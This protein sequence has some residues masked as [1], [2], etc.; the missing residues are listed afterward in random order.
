MKLQKFESIVEAEN[1]LAEKLGREG[2]HVYRKHD[3]NNLKNWFME[4]NYQYSF[5]FDVVAEDL[6][7][8]IINVYEVLDVGKRNFA[9]SLKAFIV[10]S[11]MVRYRITDT[12]TIAR[13]NLNIVFK[14]ALIG[15]GNLGPAY[16]PTRYLKIA[17]MFGVTPFCL[18]THDPI[19][20]E[21]IGDV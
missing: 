1:Y 21:V 19:T 18:G 15:E 5:T 20:L 8:G 2:R 10:K 11:R 3:I 4:N 6:Q 13:S 7:R 17:N 9:S 12:G 16:D 14:L